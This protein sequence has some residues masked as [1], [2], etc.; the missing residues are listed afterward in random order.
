[1]G[2]FISAQLQFGLNRS[3]VSLRL[4]YTRHLQGMM[5]VVVVFEMCYRSSVG[6][7]CLFIQSDQFSLLSGYRALSHPLT[8]LS[9]FDCGSGSPAAQCSHREIVFSSA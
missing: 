9:F 6:R 4:L 7:V 2:P 1:M 5:L 3:V 8:L